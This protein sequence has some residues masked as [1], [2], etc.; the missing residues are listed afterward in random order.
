MFGIALTHTSFMR[1][2]GFDIK[3]T[4]ETSCVAE[5]MRMYQALTK[6]KQK[7]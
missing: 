2:Y 1:A 3:T 7:S 4:I 5:L 6:E